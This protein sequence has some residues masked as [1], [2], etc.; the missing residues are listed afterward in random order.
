MGVKTKGFENGYEAMVSV[1]TSA[2]IAA[3][4][5]MGWDNI[6]GLYKKTPTAV[7]LTTVSAASADIEFAAAS[8]A[9]EYGS[10]QIVSAVTGLSTLKL[11]TNYTTKV[12]TLTSVTTNGTIVVSYNRMDYEPSAILSE[13]VGTTATTQPKAVAK[14]LVNGVVADSDLYGTLSADVKARLARNGIVVLEREEV[15]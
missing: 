2:T 9:I 5:V 8:A 13:V 15:K 7:S 12:M 11:S 4:T 6:T 1:P 10:P 14:A 3:K